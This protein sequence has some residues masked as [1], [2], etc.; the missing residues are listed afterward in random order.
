VRSAAR[1]AWAIAPV[2]AA[3][4]VHV[5]VLKA[6]LLPRLAIPLDGG[7][8]VLGSNKTLRGLILMPAATAAACRL[9]AA[10][11]QRY[12]RLGELSVLKTEPW[13]AGAV[14]GTAYIA[15]ELPN[16]LVKRRLGI[17]AG[18]HAPGVAGALQYVADQGDSVLGCLVMLQLVGRAPVRV[19]L[20]AG[21]MGFGAHAAVDL[22]MR[23]IGLRGR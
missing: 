20:L 5:A 16:S 1:A 2:L 8:N 13:T 14:L 10:L 19:T 22:L 6:D 21:G 9:Q 15:A 12:L 17:P 3:G 23:G 18:G 7:R 4:L 11:E